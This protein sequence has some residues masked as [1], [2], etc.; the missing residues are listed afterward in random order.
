[1]KATITEWEEQNGRLVG[2][3]S[4]AINIPMVNPQNASIIEI[5]PVI[6]DYRQIFYNA[7]LM[8]GYKWHKYTFNDSNKLFEIIIN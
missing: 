8:S 7:R 2:W 6:I 5:K 4:E 3:E 1:M